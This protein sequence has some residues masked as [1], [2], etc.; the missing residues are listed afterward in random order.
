MPESK[1][2]VKNT[3]LRQAILT[4]PEV[5][6][7]LEGILGRSIVYK[8]LRGGKIPARRI[9]RKFLVSREKLYEWLLDARGDE[10]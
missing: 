7:E 1:A 2:R 8:L 10:A 3:E 4:A 5:V 6:R 9:G